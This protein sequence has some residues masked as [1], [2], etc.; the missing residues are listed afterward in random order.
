MCLH[1]FLLLLLLLQ[2]VEQLPICYQ[3]KKVIQI[4]QYAVNLSLSPFFIVSWLWMD[5]DD[6]KC[7]KY[8][9]C[10]TLL[11]VLHYYSFICPFTHND[12]SFVIR[13]IVFI[14]F[15]SA[16]FFLWLFS[17]EWNACLDYSKLIDVS[18]V[19]FAG[20]EGCSSCTSAPSLIPDAWQIGLTET[21]CCS[22]PFSQNEIIN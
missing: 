14:H 7:F 6:E 20:F 17:F 11:F 18:N 9:E 15:D 8:A 5:S 16:D 4:H 2:S 12:S 13:L 22:L 3:H 21:C 1:P 10:K 19:C